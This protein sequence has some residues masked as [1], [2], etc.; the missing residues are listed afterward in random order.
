MRPR[1][2]LLLASM[3]LSGIL[4]LAAVEGLL[5]LWRPPQLAVAGRNIALQ[6]NTVTENNY[7]YDSA[8][9]ASHIIIRKNSLGFRGPEPPLNFSDRL[10]L[11]A[12]G[13]ST[14]ECVFIT[15]GHTWTD[16]LSH[17][18]RGSFPALWINNAGIDGHSTVG[19]TELMKQYVGQLQPDYALFLVGI[20]DMA[21]AA[22]GKQDGIPVV[23]SQGHSAGEVR[24][25]LWDRSL[26][27]AWL[28]YLRSPKGT[29]TVISTSDW[30]VQYDIQSDGKRLPLTSAD[31]AHYRQAVTAYRQ[32]LETL[33]KLT[34]GYAIKPI[35]VT[36]P[37]VYGSGIDDVTGVDL[38]R[39]AVSDFTEPGVTR[40]GA[41]KW[42]ILQLYNQATRE[43]GEALG[44][45]VIDLAREM[46]KSTAYYYDYVHFTDAGAAKAAEI[47]GKHLLSVLA[48][49]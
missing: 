16:V 12:V 34:R 11:I 18:L 3:L 43:T 47:L 45:P 17:Q 13:G 46:P 33:M 42:L 31:V 48:A 19:H 37:A 6:K 39:V 1:P 7:P 49:D 21:L 25:T 14:T 23:D 30:I 27:V 10:T 40:T 8:K 22:G 41:D 36:Q 15:E 38:A 29:H 2:R 28:R 5:R 35:L 20:N 24:A 4:S 32:R 44:I 9:I 26:I